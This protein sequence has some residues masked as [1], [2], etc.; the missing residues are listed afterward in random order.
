M[1]TDTEW[2]SPKLHSASS[3][4]DT[5]ADSRRLPAHLPPSA[6]RSSLVP[7]RRSDRRRRTSGAR[8]ALPEPR[9]LVARVQRARPGRGESERGAAPRAPQVPRHRLEQ[10]RRVL[11]GPR[12]GPQAAAHRRGR[13][14]PP[15][16]LT[17]NEQLAA[18]SDARPRARRRAVRASRRS[19]CRARRAGDRPREAERARPPKRSPSST[20]ASTTRS[21]RS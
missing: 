16:G 17:V 21:F 8:R 1:M 18:I 15:D 20:S 4:R 14:D 10:P 3:R 12:R 5:I 11:H 13:R 2:T 9:A 7:S 19:S 6:R